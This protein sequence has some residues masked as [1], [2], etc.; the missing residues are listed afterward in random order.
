MAQFIWTWLSVTISLLFPLMMTML[1]TSTSVPH[2]WRSNCA[3]TTM[4]ANNSQY[5]TNLNAV[6]RSLTSN[7]TNP[8]GYS[9]AISTNG[10][11]ETVYGHF[12]CRGD[13]SASSCRDCVDT[14]TTS[15]I[16]L[17]SCPNSW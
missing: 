1:P 15:D 10:S 8:T 3:D 6:Y 5:E 9:Q 4:F 7:A 12:L 17:N 11:N 14:A 16:P 2:L 13:Q